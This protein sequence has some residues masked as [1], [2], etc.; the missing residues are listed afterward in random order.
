MT[1]D[2]SRWGV[3]DVRI[4]VRGDRVVIQ[5]KAPDASCVV[6]GDVDC[7]F[8]APVYDHHPEFIRGIV[9]EWLEHEMDECLF[10]DGK[11]V[12]EPHIEGALI[13]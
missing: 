9:R 7:V 10:I 1:I 6:D 2:M 11:R 8:E 13:R 12:R 5:W 3:R 4:D